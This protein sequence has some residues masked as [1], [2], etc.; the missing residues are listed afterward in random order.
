[1]NDFVAIDF[2]TA[3][4]EPTSICAVGAVKVEG[5]MITDRFYCLVKPEPDYYIRRFT[6]QIHGI[7][8]SDT[9][10]A[11]GFWRI[12]PDLC[13]FIGRL[14][15]VAHNKRFDERCLRATCRCYGIDYPDYDFYCT[16][17][18]ARRTIPRTLCASFSLPSLAGFLGIPFDNHHNALADAVAC[19]YVWFYLT[20]GKR[21]IEKS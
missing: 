2:E 20:E 4:A 10:D 13:A 16:L 1:M 3:N 18:K 14:P 21:L 5:G 15:L 9:E 7:G 11:P 19:G 12:W 8:P 6:E 17:E